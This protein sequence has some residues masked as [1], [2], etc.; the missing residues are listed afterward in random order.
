MGR[1]RTTVTADLGEVIAVLSGIW[2]ATVTTTR[3]SGLTFPAASEAMAT[4]VCRPAL[5]LAVFQETEYGGLS[6]VPRTFRL[7]PS[8]R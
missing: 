2:S 6:R 7:G 1:P 3:V 8:S 4:S 5:V